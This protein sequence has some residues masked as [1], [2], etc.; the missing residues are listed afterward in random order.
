MNVDHNVKKKNLIFHNT[1]P[2][3]GEKHNGKMNDHQSRMLII[4]GV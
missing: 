2:K 4:F 1:R 3:P